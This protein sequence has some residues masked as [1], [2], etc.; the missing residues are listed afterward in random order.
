MKIQE[1]SNN[2][3]QLLHLHDNRLPVYRWNSCVSCN[4][5]DAAIRE[6]VDLY[7]RYCR[8]LSPERCYI[9]SN[10]RLC[11][12]TC[13]EHFDTL[14]A[15]ELQSKPQIKMD[16][17]VG[18][19][20]DC[21]GL[22]GYMEYSNDLDLYIDVKGTKCYFGD[23]DPESCDQPTDR[24]YEDGYQYQCCGTCAQAIVPIPGNTP[25]TDHVPTMSVQ[26]YQ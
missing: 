23:R 12:Q 4:V 20:G 6:C 19:L 26:Y 25:T 5:S 9:K 18:V 15:K 10:L 16:F 14:S 24:C 1:F 11:C 7:D 17:R 13:Q 8:S 21:V 22:T 2:S 3:S